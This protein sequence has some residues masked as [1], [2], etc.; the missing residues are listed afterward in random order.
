[1]PKSAK[2]P[3]SKS[4]ARRAKAATKR[5]AVK[6]APKAKSARKPAPARGRAKVNHRPAP[7]AVVATPAPAVK[8]G[9]NAA[10]LG[11]KDI[12]YFR[13][14]LLAKRRELLGDVT[15]MET[16]ALQNGP[17]VG[18][19]S[20]LPDHMADQGTD[21]YEQE[22]T[23]GLMEKDRQ[24]LREIDIALQKIV[25]GTYGICEGTGKPISRARLEAQPWARHGIE[26]A[27]KIESGM[28]GMR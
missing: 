4:G 12:A 23:L 5:P 2:K 6:A 18:N 10:G 8:R 19:L 17:G 3:S 20:N 24:L 16:E 11:T 28:R 15:S 21:N 13:D 25:N 26:H 9:K 27:R 1:V 7:P 14:L 22:F